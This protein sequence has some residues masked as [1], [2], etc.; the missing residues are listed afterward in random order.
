MADS[1]INQTAGSRRHAAPPQPSAMDL[2]NIDR[3]LTEDERMVRDTV[4]AFTRERAET[5]RGDETGRGR[6]QHGRDTVPAFLQAP[7]DLERLIGGDPTADPQ[8]D[9]CRSA[10]RRLGAHW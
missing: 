6:G 2:Y 3:L 7:Q 9:A 8:D 5:Q 10:L 1:V 4:R